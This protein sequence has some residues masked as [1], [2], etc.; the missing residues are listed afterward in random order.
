MPTLN[1]AEPKPGI[2]KGVSFEDYVKIDAIN[3]STLK[4]FADQSPAHA[5][6][7]MLNGRPETPALSFGSAADCF[8][9]E[10]NLF[11]EQ[12]VEGPDARRNSNVWK[13]F[14]A[15]NTDK[16]ILKPAEMQAILGIYEKISNNPGMRL[17]TGGTSQIVLVWVDDK[18]GLLCKARLDYLNPELAIITD[19]KTTKSAHPRH[20]SK[21]IAKYKYHNQAGFYIDGYCKVTGEKSDMCCWCFFAVEKEE[22]YVA[23][24][25]QLGE[26][27][28]EA[29]RMSYRIALDAY[30]EC[31]KTNTWPA[32]SN[33]TLPIE[34]PE[35]ALE[36]AGLG[37][38]NISN[39]D[40]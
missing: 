27:S 11:Y 4:I 32:Y 9:L 24:G 15:E 1:T 23:Q 25:Y 39:M 17:I 6:H 34:V 29:G 16:T 22:P 20:F 40:F 14:A 36:R 26:R 35:W 30:A 8:I 12:Y 19:L 18:T 33:E 38:H 10:Q 28:I 13:Q 21:D 31:V 5:R 7:Y 2:Y 37:T 3:N